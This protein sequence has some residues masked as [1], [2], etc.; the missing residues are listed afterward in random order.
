MGQP[1]P[2]LAYAEQAR[3]TVTSTSAAI[4]QKIKDMADAAGCTTETVSISGT[5]AQVGIKFTTS[6]VSDLRVV[7]FAHSAK[8]SVTMLT[9]DTEVAN[10]LMV[11]IS[12]GVTVETMSSC[13]SGGNP[14]GSTTF[15][16]FWKCSTVTTSLNRIWMLFSGESLLLALD[17]NSGTSVCYAHAGAVIDP[18]SEASGNCETSGRVYGMWVTSATALAAASWSS[19]SESFWNHFLNDGTHSHAGAWQPRTT[20]WTRLKRSYAGTAISPA[21]STAMFK[22]VDGASVARQIELEDIASPFAYYG[23]VRE[24]S[25]WHDDDHAKSISR[26]V[27]GSSTICGYVCGSTIGAATD[28]MFV[29]KIDNRSPN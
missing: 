11:G 23:R 13:V 4:L 12:K 19:P 25:Y 18:H 29:A 26:T 28:A 6:D 7:F 5:L 8:Q 16:G 10:I 9:P 1:L 27:G 15:S 22:A 17:A 3:A 21:P 2:L 24:C 14:Y 20:T